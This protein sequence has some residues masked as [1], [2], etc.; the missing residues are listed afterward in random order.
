MKFLAVNLA[1]RIIF[2]FI[3]L[4]VSF[5]VWG[6]GPAPLGVIAVRDLPVEAQETLLLIKRGGPYPYARDGVIF[7]NYEGIL[8]RR[9]RGYYREFTVKTPGV[10]HRGARR[11]ISGGAPQQGQEYFYTDDHYVSFKRIRE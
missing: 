8:P 5:S 6:K 10:R 11:I 2:A 9:E 4:L 1:K 3:A 7:K